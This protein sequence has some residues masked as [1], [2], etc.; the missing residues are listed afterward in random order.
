MEPAARSIG[1][2]GDPPC[3]SG[4]VD[5]PFAGSPARKAA[6]KVV[7]KEGLLPWNEF[8]GLVRSVV[9]LLALGSCRGLTQ[10]E[11]KGSDENRRIELVR[12]KSHRS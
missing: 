10:R 3:L 4:L 8:K 9:W 11:E 6:R 2:G 7:K 12:R 5:I 1:K